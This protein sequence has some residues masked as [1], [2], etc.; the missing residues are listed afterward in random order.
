MCGGV[1]PCAVPLAQPQAN[2]QP[3]IAHTTVLPCSVT[4]CDAPA[5]AGLGAHGPLVQNS[6]AGIVVMQNFEAAEVSAC[7]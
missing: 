5:V 6:L 1:G 2:L 4:S 3:T 7:V